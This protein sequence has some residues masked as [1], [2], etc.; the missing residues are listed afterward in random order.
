MGTRLQ[1]RRFALEQRL[2]VPPKAG[3]YNAVVRKEFWLGKQNFSGQQAAQ[4]LADEHIGI[5]GFVL[6]LDIGL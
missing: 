1:Y 6:L 4:R 5:V 2:I 3:T